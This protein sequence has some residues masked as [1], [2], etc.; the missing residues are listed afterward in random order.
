MSVQVPRFFCARFPLSFFPISSLVR[1]SYALGL[2]PTWHCDVEKEKQRLVEKGKQGGEREQ[3]VFL[4]IFSISSFFETTTFFNLPLS[5]LPFRAAAPSGP[6]PPSFQRQGR[7]PGLQQP[8]PR[9]HEGPRRCPRPP[10]PCL[11]APEPGREGPS[12]CCLGRRLRPPEQLPRPR[13]GWL[14]P[15]GPRR[16]GERLLP[17]AAALLQR[18]PGAVRLR[19]RRGRQELALLSPRGRLRRFV[20]RPLY[21]FQQ[22]RS[23]PEQQEQ[24]RRL[25][26]LGASSSCDLLLLLLALLLLLP[27]H[28]RQFSRLRPPQGAWREA[29]WGKE[30]ERAR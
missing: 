3:S 11:R 17:A 27:F 29:A 12:R 24:L 14:L 26:P 9:R 25:A 20:E 4:F 19:E 7:R 18:A 30:G 1:H 2:P 23:S 22:G 13:P 28:L 16:W 15:R 8:R 6:P 5:L 21:R 10:P